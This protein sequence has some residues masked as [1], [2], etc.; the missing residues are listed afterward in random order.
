MNNMK[1]RMKLIAAFTLAVCL[2]VAMIAGVVASLVF[3][4]L[5]GILIVPVVMFVGFLLISLC[6]DK[7][8]E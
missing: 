5:F 3:F 7:V 6:L 1:S 8:V 4:K 2:S